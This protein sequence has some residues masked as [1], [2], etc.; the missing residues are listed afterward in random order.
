MENGFYKYLEAEQLE[1][2][3]QIKQGT[4]IHSTGHAQRRL[5]KEE[6]T[7]LPVLNLKGSLDRDGG[8]PNM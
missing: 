5:T 8:C 4:G 7:D 1:L 2:C 3:W 6:R